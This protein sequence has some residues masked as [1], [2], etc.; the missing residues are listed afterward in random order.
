MTDHFSIGNDELEKLPEAEELAQCPRC[1]GVHPIV[2]ST[3]PKG[4]PTRVLGTVLCEGK[5]WLVAVAGKLIPPN[6]F[7]SPKRAATA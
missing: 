2:W 4:Q 3:D 6:T 1:L 7:K 5:H